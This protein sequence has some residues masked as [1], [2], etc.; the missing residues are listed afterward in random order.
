MYKNILVWGM[1]STRLA[2]FSLIK[3][4]IFFNHMAYG[5]VDLHVPSKYFRQMMLKYFN[6]LLTYQHYARKG[7]MANSIFQ[8]ID[9]VVYYYK[10]SFSNS[11]FSNSFPF[12]SLACWGL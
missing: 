1:T 3:V 8:R 4:I 11:F 10:T 2:Y 5:I 9:S 12:F 6:L 7:Y